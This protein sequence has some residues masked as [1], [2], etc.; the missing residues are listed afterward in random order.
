MLMNPDTERIELQG[1]GWWEIKKWLS[2]GDRKK[3][4]Q[5]ERTWVSAKEGITPEEIK[6]NP[7]AALQLNTANMDVDARDDLMLQLG[8]VGWS[9]DEEFSLE[10]ADKLQDTIVQ[11]VLDRM[12]VLYSGLTPEVAAEAKKD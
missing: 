9:F 2:R 11:V 8:T 3:L 5:M 6:N 7:G 1:G 12:Q 10:A 4:N